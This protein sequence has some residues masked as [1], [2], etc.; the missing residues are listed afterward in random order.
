MTW[1]TM[2]DIRKG[3]GTGNPGWVLACRQAVL[4]SSQA[5]RN[6]PL[7]MLTDEPSP[8]GD[9]SPIWEWWRAWQEVVADPHRGYYARQTF[10]GLLPVTC[11]AAVTAEARLARTPG[12][13]DS[14]AREL[15]FL[16]WLTVVLARANDAPVHEGRIDPPARFLPFLEHL[17]EAGRQVPMP[18]AQ[19][20]TSMARVFQEGVPVDLTAG[21]A[22]AVRAFPDNVRD[23]LGG[24]LALTARDLIRA[25]DPSRLLD[26]ATTVRV[27]FPI[28]T[29]GGAGPGLLA[30]F[31]VSWS[32]HESAKHGP[33]V[34]PALDR[35]PFIWLDA[36]FLGAVDAAAAHT[37]S[38]RAT[39]LRK[40]RGCACVEEAEVCSCDVRWWVQRRSGAGELRLGDDSVGLGAAVAMTCLFKGQIPDDRIPVTGAL[41]PIKEP[42]GSPGNQQ[43]GG[44]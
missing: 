27:T 21:L 34:Y 32:Q 22:M 11:A 14:D 41:G 2:E 15:A 30:E 20:L 43:D 7:T 1:P 38:L 37:A 24:P 19:T 6:I 42:A 35:M 40:I 4:D 36:A 23:W 44:R 25:V 3:S 5:G 28:V 10:S 17:R 29:E 39:S 26:G 12:R 18:P 31:H 13:P 9:P 33:A 16:V 8:Q